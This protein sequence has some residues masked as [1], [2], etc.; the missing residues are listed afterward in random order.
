MFFVFRHGSNIFKNLVYLVML[1]WR[2]FQYSNFVVSSV[3]LSAQ[4]KVVP[5]KKTDFGDFPK[6][7][8][9]SQ[10]LVMP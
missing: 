6:L 3:F 10:I 5:T 2:A 9:D 1:K 7:R 4:P 8:R